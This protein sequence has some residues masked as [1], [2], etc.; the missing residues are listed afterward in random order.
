[1]IE[2]EDDERAAIRGA[3][4]QATQPT[5]REDGYLLCESW[6]MPKA[7]SSDIRTVAS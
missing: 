1:M 3:G 4:A 6:A 2:G 7:A 5:E